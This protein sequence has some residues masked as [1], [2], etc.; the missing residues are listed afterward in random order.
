MERRIEPLHSGNE[1]KVMT[2]DFSLET[3]PGLKTLRT[4]KAKDNIP[5]VTNQYEQLLVLISCKENV[6]I[7][8]S[9]ETESRQKVT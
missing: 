1:C 8:L 5:G 7:P 9:A 4:T 6:E 3:T 2:K